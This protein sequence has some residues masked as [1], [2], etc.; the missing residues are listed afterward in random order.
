MKNT[1]EILLKTAAEMF[2]KHDFDSISTRD[3][4]KKSGVN[5]CS[6]NY[7]FGSKQKLYEAVTDYV[8]SFV[9]QNL[10]LKLRREIEAGASVMPPRGQIKNMLNYFLYLLCGTEI[11]ETVVELLFKELIK[12]TDVYGRFYTGIFEP[13]HK[14]LTELIS[15]DTGLRDKKR[16]IVLA[17]CILG[18]A[19]MFKLHREALLRRLGAEEYTPELLSEIQEQI[20]QNVDAI[21]D[22]AKEN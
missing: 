15:L 7:Y 22:G 20:R 11:P 8:Y 10:S 18:Q 21:L 16:L 2:A 3:L 19:V 13:V 1:K 4:A 6:I 14:K 9:E 17:H 5:L 12:P